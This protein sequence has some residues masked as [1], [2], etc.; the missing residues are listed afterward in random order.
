MPSAVALFLRTS[1]LGFSLVVSPH[2][3]AMSKRGSGWSN[4]VGREC[5]LSEQEV[6]GNNS[7]CPLR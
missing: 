5:W 6:G 3:R 2:S 4:C 1:W 7:Q